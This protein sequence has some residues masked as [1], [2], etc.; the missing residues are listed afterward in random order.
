MNTKKLQHYIERANERGMLNWLPDTYCLRLIYWARLGKRL[1]LKNPRTYNEK[2]QW[3]KVHNRKPVYNRMVDKYEAKQYIAEKIGEAY[4]IPTLGVWE[5]FEDIDVASLPDRFVLKCT[6]D[7]GGLVVVRDKAQMDLAAAKSKIEKSL[8]TNY[9][10]HGREWPYKDVKPRILAE[11]YVEDP[12]LKELRDYKFYCFQGVPRLMAIFCGRSAGATTADYFDM[13]FQPVDLTWGYAKAEK[14]PAK[15]E[16]FE[17][18]QEFA[19]L[20]SKDVPALRVD[21]YEVNGK[22]YVGELTFFDGSGFDVIQPIE[23]DER[24]GSW[25]DLTE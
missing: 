5:R 25:L 13:S 18:M 19:A 1:N 4:T 15:P 24:M 12:E 23:W 21:F 10:Y 9:Y 11:S 14:T 6:H 3:L 16:N 17:K 8:K 7:S 22:V 20:L 2:L